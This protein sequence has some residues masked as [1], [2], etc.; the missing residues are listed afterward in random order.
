V[1]LTVWQP[2]E[3][4]MLAFHRGDQGATIVVYDDFERDEVPVSYFFRGPEQFPPVEQIALQLCRGRVLD[5]GAGS[6]CH[7]LA[8]QER[9]IE[10]TAI[11][12]LPGLVDILRERGVRDARMASWQNLEAEPFDTVLLL[13]NGL[14][15]AE[16]L[17]G[18]RRF[19]GEIRRLLRPGG[20]ILADSTDVRS[21]M[22]PAAGRGGTVMRSDGR[23]IGELHLQLEFQG[24]KGDPFPQLYVD[25][26]TLT[27]Y[28]EGEGWS[29]E[30]VSP[31]DKYGN[32]LA[33]L[34][35][36]NL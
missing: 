23:Y 11:E 3:A 5:V 12:V 9:G 26:E 34:L 21:R 4:A 33:R 35:P 25:P 2:H 15:L 24:R 16:T 13:M 32:Y 22:D 10:V 8:L 6:G 30:I 28:A 29:C 18:L 1:D 14:G 17:I 27:R 36:R 20:Q 31:R 19:L 7:S